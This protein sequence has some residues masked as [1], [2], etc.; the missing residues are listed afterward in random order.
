MAREFAR[1]LLSV[2]GDEGWK[3]LSSSD[4]DVFVSLLTSP[5]LS[6]CG[7]A[8]LLPQRLVEFSAD[9]TLRKVQGS[10]RALEDAGLVV[11]DTSTGEILVRSYVRHDG[12]MSKPNI[13]KAMIRARSKVRSQLIRDALNAELGRIHEEAP[14]L[15]GWSTMIDVAPNIMA[16]CSRNSSRN[17]SPKGSRNR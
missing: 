17:S 7:V 14:S 15:A 9:L 10:L 6:W 1:I 12:V 8:P 5:D 11:T 2:W 4:H 3:S 13:V 16:N